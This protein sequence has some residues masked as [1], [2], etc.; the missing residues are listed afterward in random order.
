MLIWAWILLLFSSN[1]N[2][3]LPRIAERTFF[4][5]NLVI[6]TV[7]IFTLFHQIE[8]VRLVALSTEMK[9]LVEPDGPCFVY[10]NGAG[11]DL[12]RFPGVWRDDLIPVLSGPTFC[13]SQIALYCG[14]L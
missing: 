11:F 4:S 3:Y 10:P 2:L 1:L 7:V 14:A 12:N 9:I 13:E 8:P 5:F 6:F